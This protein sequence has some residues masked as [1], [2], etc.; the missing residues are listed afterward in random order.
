M[1]TVWFFSCPKTAGG[2][3]TGHNVRPPAHASSKLQS[4]IL[5]GCLSESKVQSCSVTSD[6][7]KKQG[8]GVVLL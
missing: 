4:Q 7:S 3:G 2:L 6:L 8:S 1:Y 5:N